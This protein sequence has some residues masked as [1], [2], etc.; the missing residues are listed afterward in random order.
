MG[1]AGI[2]SKGFIIKSHK[3]NRAIDRQ[4]GLSLPGAFLPF[5][6]ADPYLQDPASPVEC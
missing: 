3:Q 2:G 6:T 5:S 1:S 4:I